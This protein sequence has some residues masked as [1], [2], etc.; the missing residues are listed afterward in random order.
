M[1]KLHWT[2]WFSEDYMSNGLVF[3]YTFYH[4]GYHQ[5]YSFVF[6][7]TSYSLRSFL[8]VMLAWLSVDFIPLLSTLLAKSSPGN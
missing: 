1:S 3:H 8:S 7:Y 5:V 4:F 6:H 2:A